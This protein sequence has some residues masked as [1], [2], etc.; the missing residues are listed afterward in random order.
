MDSSNKQQQTNKQT[1]NKKRGCA[2]ICCHP[3][4]T[5]KQTT[6]KKNPTRNPQTNRSLLLL[7]FRWKSSV[8]FGAVFETSVVLHDK[9]VWFL[10]LSLDWRWVR[11]GGKEGFKFILFCYGW[12]CV[13][14]SFC[15][16]LCWMRP[17][18][19]FFRFWGQK[20]KNNKKPTSFNR[21]SHWMDLKASHMSG[22]CSCFMKM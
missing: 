12:V 13:W 10:M 4:P 11:S 7:L 21:N 5:P 1:E 14:N 2:S 20:K 15:S 6:K 22:F 18:I 19:I 8:V 3:T 16:V 9:P 17:K